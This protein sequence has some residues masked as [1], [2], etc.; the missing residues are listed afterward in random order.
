MTRIWIKGQQ[1]SDTAE[2]ETERV[3]E[4]SKA[5]MFRGSTSRMASGSFEAFLEDILLKE[6]K[7]TPDAQLRI[8]APELLCLKSFLQLF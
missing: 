3:P 4:F 5:E 6:L 1:Q 8:C 7:E 2:R